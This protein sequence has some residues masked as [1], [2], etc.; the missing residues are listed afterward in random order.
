MNIINIIGFLFT[1]IPGSFIYVLANFGHPK[2]SKPNFSNI[3]KLI[4]ISSIYACVEY[5]FKMPSY[6]IFGLKMFSQLT[7]QMIWFTMTTIGVILFEKYYLK[8]TIP[9]SSYMCVFGIL[10]LLYIESHLRKK[11]KI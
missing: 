1:I 6:Y 8:Q 11:N 5:A 7:L 3:T 9:L 10:V 4:I 2:I